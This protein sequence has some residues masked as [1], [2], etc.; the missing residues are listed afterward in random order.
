MDEIDQLY[1]QNSISY[2]EFL[3][4][5]ESFTS[6]MI[7]L[8]IHWEINPISKGSSLYD[9]YCGLKVFEETMRD[10]SQVLEGVMLYNND[11]DDNVIIEL[12]KG[13][14]TI[15]PSLRNLNKLSHQLCLDYGL[16]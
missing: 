6:N 12:A 14:D 5:H 1:M 9:I 7:K 8:H 15:L 16:L 11:L 3:I 2:E 10:V 4:L 13:F